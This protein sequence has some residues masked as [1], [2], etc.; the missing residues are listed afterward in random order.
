MDLLLQQSN[1]SR[2]GDGSS[3]LPPN[4]T[5][6][7]LNQSI[8]DHVKVQESNA[9]PTLSPQFSTRQD[10]LSASSAKKTAQLTSSIT[11]GGSQVQGKLN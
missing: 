11:I 8:D 1:D 6:Q 3:A 4:I 5:D 9:G 2:I 10:V 7:F